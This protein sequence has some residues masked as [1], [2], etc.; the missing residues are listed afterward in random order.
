M[1]GMA[2]GF[3]QASGKPALVNLHTA[4]GVG[5][6]MGAIFNAQANKSPLRR[7]RRPAGALADDAAGEPDQPRRRRGC[8][9]PL[10]KWSYEPP[11]A[12]DVPHALARAIHLAA[13]P[14]QGPVVRLDPDGRLGGR[15]RRGRRRAT[16]TRAPVERPRGRR[17]RARCATRRSGSRGAASPVLVAGPDVDA[18]GGWDAAVA[19]AERAAAAGVGDAR[20]GRRAGSASRRTTRTSSGVLPPAIGPL[21][22]TLEG[23]DLVLVVG[24]VGLPVLPE[25]PGA[26]AAR[27]HGAGG[28]HERSR[29]G[30]AR[31]DGRRDRRRRRAHARGA[32][33]GRRR[34]RTASRAG[35]AAGAPEPPEESRPDEPLGAVHA[36]LA[37]VFPDDG[38]VVLESPSSTL[39]LRN[40]LR[41]SRP[42]SYF[43]GAGGG[44]GFGLVGGG[45]RAARAAR[46]ARS[47]ACS[48]RAR[49]STRSRRSGRAAAYEVPVTFLVLRNEE[50]AILKWFAELEQVDGRAG[51]RPA[52]RSTRAAIAAGYGVEARGA[53]T[54]ATSSAPRSRRRSRRAQPELVEVRVTPGWRSSRPVRRGSARARRPAHRRP[55]GAPDAGPR[56]RLARRRA[57][58]E[59]LRSDLSR[60]LGRGSRAAAAR[61]T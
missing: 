43:F 16:Q 25:H 18:S 37:E 12:E 31:A 28:D 8:P 23:H 3:A 17:P 60:S 38:I 55:V 14:P 40:R 53:S 19:L 11:R 7:H 29:R 45:R 5:N 30:G 49:C 13:L 51:P 21:G 52:R 20:A 44:L 46:A 34:S 15:G 4:P 41:L 32:A 9:H 36:A 61:S 54:G 10:V 35:A 56:A 2:D 39:A 42:G 6:A 1:V 47:C 26:A 22:Q 27:G 48:A 57:R 33:R 59:P 58:R 50:Y 24:A